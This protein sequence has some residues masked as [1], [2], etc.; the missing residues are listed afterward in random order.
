VFLHGKGAIFSIFLDFYKKGVPF[1]LDPPWKCLKRALFGPF[2]PFLRPFRL[3]FSIRGFESCL[4]M[5]S[6]F[7]SMKTGLL[8]SDICPKTAFSERIRALFVLFGI[9]PDS[10]F[11]LNPSWNLTIF[12]KTGFLWVL[13]RPPFSP[14]SEP[15]KN[16]LFFW[17]ISTILLGQKTALPLK[18]GSP[19]MDL[20]L[21][22]KP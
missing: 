17:L 7:S 15:I 12:Q 2:W 20:T 8:F 1:F 19:H 21:I 4:F 6:G 5:F 9:S 10:R 16:A 18:T 3:F 13:R 22:F 14:F 11:Y